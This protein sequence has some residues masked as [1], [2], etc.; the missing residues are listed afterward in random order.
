MS[1]QY[2]NAGNGSMERNKEKRSDK[3]PDFKGR[4]TIDGK[5]FWLSGWNREDRDGN[6][7]IS[8]AFE[9][10]LARDHKGAPSNPPPRTIAGKNEQ[11]PLRDPESSGDEFN[12]EIPF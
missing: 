9:P 4:V 3:S 10:K 2:Q 1:G 8:L 11:P 6:Q 12:D 7:F 5:Q